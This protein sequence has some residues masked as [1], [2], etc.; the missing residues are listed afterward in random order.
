MAENSKNTDINFYEVHSDTGLETLKKY[1]DYESS[2]IHLHKV[3]E[4]KEDN[5]YIGDCRMTD[6]FNTRNVPDKAKTISLGGLDESTISQ[7]KSKTLSEILMQII[8]PRV[9]PEPPSEKPNMTI[10][11]SGNNLIKVGTVL[12]SRSDIRCSYDRGQWTDGT[13]YAG[14][15]GEPTLTMNLDKWGQES[16]EGNYIISGKVQFNK[17]TK[18]KDSY[19]V[20]YNKYY[21]GGDVSSNNIRITSVYPIQINTDDITEMKEQSLVD[22]IN[23][24]PVLHIT[25]PAEI[26]GTLDKFKIYLPYEFKSI[27]VNQYN[28]VSGKYDIQ[29]EMP[30]MDDCSYH[31][32]RTKDTKNTNT[33]FVKYEIKLTR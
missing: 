7:L 5:L 15:Y 31:Y 4:D 6:N 27:E 18:P 32:I 19:G 16:D 11:Y 2:F 1:P 25:V 3:N 33:G 29:I 28:P 26:D 14:E 12:P 9:N 17:G 20:E 10:S 24:N 13:V 8:C 22:Y 23:S 30:P 21:E